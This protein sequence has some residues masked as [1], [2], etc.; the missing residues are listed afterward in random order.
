MFDQPEAPVDLGM[1]NWLLCLTAIAWALPLL[2]SFIEGVSAADGGAEVATC[3]ELSDFVHP[4][5]H[6]VQGHV[7]VAGIVT[8]TAMRRGRRADFMYPGR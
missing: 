4:A 2:W 6:E 5:G 3:A 8:F 1:Q 7:V